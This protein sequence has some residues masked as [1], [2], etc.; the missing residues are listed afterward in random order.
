VRACVRA[1]ARAML[2]VIVGGVYPSRLRRPLN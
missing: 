1:C 2:Y